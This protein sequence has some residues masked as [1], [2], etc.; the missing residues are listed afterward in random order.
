MANACLGLVAT[1]WLGYEFYRFFGQPAAIGA[2]P[3]HPGAIDF[4]I[5]RDMV[6]A[7]F[8]GAPVY[9]GSTARLN[10]HPPASML[11]LWP[12]YGFPVRSLAI[13]VWTTAT[14]ASLAAL[15]SLGVRAS[16]AEQ[17]DPR[18]FVALIPF[19][20]YPAGAIIGNGQSTLIALTAM[21]A[22]LLLARRPAPRLL[23]DAA[24]ALLM[25]VAL[26][27]P[28]VTVPFFW[29]AVLAAPR[30]RVPFAA[31]AAYGAATIVAGSVRDASLPVLFAQ[32]LELAARLSTR[33]GES[34]LHTL[35]ASAGLQRYIG[36]ASLGVLLAHGAWVW[37]HRRV[38]AWLLIGVTGLVARFWTYHRWYDDLLVVPALFACC[39]VAN[40]RDVT[41]AERAS[42]LVSLAVA[43]AGLVAPGGLYVLPA[44][45]VEP[46]KA[47]QVTTWLATAVVLAIVAWRDR[48]AGRDGPVAVD[49]RLSA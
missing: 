11:L 1:I 31:I 4:D 39:R 35:F 24:A 26:I 28:S 12:F 22:G 29:V 37:C 48:C 38:D 27:K 41:R 7:W 3:I 34:N 30:L 33:A 20:T 5:L 40:R 42:A 19:A 6:R 21:L 23:H 2:R 45:W 43:L 49:G 25:L 46:W 47:A 36:L 44:S 14:V 10:T 9:T 13:A 16:G 18:L 8:A 17:R 15:A 32:F